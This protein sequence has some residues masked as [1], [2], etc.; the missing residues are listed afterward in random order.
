MAKNDREWMIQ[1]IVRQG[2]DFAEAIKSNND[3]WIRTTM[4][5][6]ANAIADMVDSRIRELEKNR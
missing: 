3:D 5:Q 4:E 2:E 1:L 6:M